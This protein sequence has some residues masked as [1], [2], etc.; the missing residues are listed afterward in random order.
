MAKRTKKVYVTDITWNIDE[1]DI[2]T[3]GD[4][5][6]AVDELDLPDSFVIDDV[7]DV[8]KEFMDEFIKSS[9]EEKYECKMKDGYNY[10]IV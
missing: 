9:A 10:E 6:T 4:Y 2:N 7:Q 3:Y 8:D 1:E 5:D